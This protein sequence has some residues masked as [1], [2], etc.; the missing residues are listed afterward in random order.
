MPEPE[1]IQIVIT[2]TPDSQVSVTGPLDNKVLCYGLLEVAK[3]VISAYRP[4]AEKPRLVEP[5][6]AIPSIGTPF[7][8][9]Q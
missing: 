2:M 5:V 3:G 6:A 4:A 7:L 9:R 8:R 1:Q